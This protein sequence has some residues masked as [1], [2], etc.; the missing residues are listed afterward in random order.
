MYAKAGVAPLSEH[1]VRRLIKGQGVTIKAGSKHSLPM[2]KEQMKKF[3]RATKAGRGM[4]ISLDPYQQKMCGSGFE[5][6]ARDTAAY[7]RPVADA[8]MDRAIREIQG[9]GFESS[10][11]DFGTYLRPVADA[12]M[13][14]AIRE[15]QGG[16]IQSA[17]NA[18]ETDMRE[19]LKGVK[20][21]D[22]DG[23]LVRE[24]KGGRV[25][26]GKGFFEDLGRSFQ[27]TF[28]PVSAVFQ[29]NAEAERFGKQVASELIHKGIPITSGTLGGIAGSTLTGG[30][31]G[32]IAGSYLGEMAGKQLADEVGRQTGYGMK[33][34]AKGRGLM[35]DAFAMAKSQGKRV[36]KSAISKAKSKAKELVNQ[37]LDLGEK[38]A[39]DMI[40]DGLMSD[41]LALAKSKGK[42]MAKEAIGR[43]KSKA[44][45][46]VSQYLDLGEQKAQELLGEGAFGGNKKKMSGGMMRR[47]RGKA[48]L[49]A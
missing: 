20:V 21:Y 48:L 40:G 18:F 47:M 32:G 19:K 46:L 25:K 30:P 12:G 17:L 22:R 7:L 14:R 36:A 38:E 45:D 16:N 5:E 39:R 44:K 26:R 1:Q 4:V 35:S 24:K 37:Y 43:A 23:K 8:G 29:P 13:D 15:I 34:K 9:R 2:S 6:M 33:R 28:E 49:V 42:K 10:M 11:R 3:A 27:Q 31:V 41:A